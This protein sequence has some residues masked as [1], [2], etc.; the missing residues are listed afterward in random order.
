MNI[1]TVVDNI[2]TASSTF[3]F[4]KILL[5]IC[6]GKTWSQIWCSQCSWNLVQGNIAIRCLR[7]W[8]LFFQNFFQASFLGKV[9]PKT[10]CSLNLLKFDTGSA[11]CYK[12]I[13]IL[14]YFSK[15]C[16]LVGFGQTCSQNFMLSKLT[17]IWHRGSCNCCML[18]FS[19]S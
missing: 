7:F 17:E 12:L 18:N 19:G 13:K 10:W 11:Y 15:F 8:Y 9:C 14:I 4:S 6:Y 16:R 3:V 1:S 5:F 2:L